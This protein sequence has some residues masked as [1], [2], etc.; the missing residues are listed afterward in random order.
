M[1]KKEKEIINAQQNKQMKELVQFQYLL[2]TDH[3]K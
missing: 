2:T 3:D 1:I